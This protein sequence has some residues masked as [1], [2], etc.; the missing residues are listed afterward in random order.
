MTP[1]SHLIAECDRR[2]PGWDRRQ[3][4][5]RE[6]CKAAEESFQ[7]WGYESSM[8]DAYIQSYVNGALDERQKIAK[9]RAAQ[10]KGE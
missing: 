1:T 5:R 10:T 6:L 4:D 2:L 3:D 9:E 7:K 8:H